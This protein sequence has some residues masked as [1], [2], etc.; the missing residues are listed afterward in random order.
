VKFL[1]PLTIWLILLAIAPYRF[2]VRLLVALGMFLTGTLALL[3]YAVGIALIVL[4]LGEV[5]GVYP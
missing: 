1:L 5:V 4:L 3:L 2:G